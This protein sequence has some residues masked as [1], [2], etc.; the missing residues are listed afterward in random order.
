MTDQII[1]DIFTIFRRHGDERY[2][3]DVTQM[4]H[5]LQCGELA[6]EDGAPDAL[7]AAALLHD[8][9][10]FLNDAGNAAER[11]GVDARHEETGAAFLAPYF[12]AAVTEP[13]RLHVEA[14][15]YLCAAETGYLD[16]LSAASA[17]SLRLQGGPHSP[18]EMAA[19][20]A[21]PGAEDAIRLRRYDDAGKRRDWV[22]PE[23]D[24]YRPLLRSLLR[25]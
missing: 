5:I 25:G 12:P 24:S 15:R 10:Q 13:V 21:L 14:K 1:D 3:E 4:E 20:L 19:F 8:L 16:Q 11:K 7:V 17:L 23:L 22:V 18:A 2:G 9:G 6:R